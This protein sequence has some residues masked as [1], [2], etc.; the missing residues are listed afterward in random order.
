MSIGSEQSDD[1]PPFIRLGDAG[2]HF[3]N[4]NADI[5]PPLISSSTPAW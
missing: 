5:A 4:V 3:M 2:I 1:L